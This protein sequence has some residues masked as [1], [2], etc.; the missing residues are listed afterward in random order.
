MAGIGSL[1]VKQICICTWDL[2]KADKNWTKLLGI[3]SKRIKTADWTFAPTYTHNKADTFEPVPGLL[4][5]LADDVFL[6][7]YGPGEGGNPFREFLDTY[8]EGVMNIAF[9]VPDLDK[10]YKLVGD[11]SQA[12]RPYHVGFWPDHTYSFIDTKPDLQVQLNLKRNE[13]NT[14]LIQRFLKDSADFDPD[15]NAMRNEEPE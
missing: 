10:A 6:E 14:A 5:V 7:I 1:K 12:D 15:F 13:D 9:Y 2:E 4:Y 8:G 3:E 11:F